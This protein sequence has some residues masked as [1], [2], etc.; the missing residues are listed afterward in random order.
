MNKTHTPWEKAYPYEGQGGWTGHNE[1]ARPN[2]QFREAHELGTRVPGH[3]SAGTI[4]ASDD[5]RK[6][7][8]KATLRVT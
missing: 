2:R 3:G 4:P 8:T 1:H 6:L 7:H 5:A